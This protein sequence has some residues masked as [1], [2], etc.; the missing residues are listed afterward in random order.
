M[1]VVSM[2]RLELD[3]LRVVMDLGEGRLTP[4]EASAR[5][6]V[7]E[8][9]VWRLLRRFRQDGGAGLASRKRGRPSNR[10][11]HPALRETILSLVRR[12]YPDFGPTLA[13][14]KLAECASASK[15][16]PDLFRLNPLIL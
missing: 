14:E 10:R 7:S 9:Q 2:S 16:A 6:Q 4:C 15:V 1:T 12:F 5:L 13:A 3:R 11:H 8:R